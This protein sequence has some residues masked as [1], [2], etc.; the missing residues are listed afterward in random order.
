[1]A[2]RKDT[3]PRTFIKIARDGTRLTR[4]VTS[5][6]SSE[7]EARFDGF[8]PENEVPSPKSSTTASTTASKPASN[9]PSS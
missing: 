7:V 9:S 2:Q 8:R 5:V 1:M 3:E 4:T 6:P